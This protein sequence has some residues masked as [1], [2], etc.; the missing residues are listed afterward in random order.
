MIGT[1]ATGALAAGASDT[2]SGTLTWSSN[3]TPG[4][5]FVSIAADYKNVISE[6]NESNNQSGKIAIVL[7]NGSANALTGTAGNDVLIGLGGKDTLTGGAGADQFLFNTALNRSTSLATI[8]DFS[9]AQGDKID[10]DHTIFTAL[11]P[12]AL[13]VRRCPRMISTP[14]PMAQPTVRLITSSTT[15][16]L[17]HC[18]TIRTAPVQQPRFSLPCSRSIRL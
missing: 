7:G 14:A 1:I 10:L 18:P 2:E 5:Y 12:E 6:S 17:A 3:T 11:T 4:I 8:T 16:Q 13:G 9:H 15:P